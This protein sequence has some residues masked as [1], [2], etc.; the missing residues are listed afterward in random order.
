MYMD[1][2]SNRRPPAEPPHV[3]GPSCSRTAGRTPLERAAERG[4]RARVRALRPASRLA[5]PRVRPP[6]VSTRGSMRRRSMKRRVE[7]STRCSRSPAA[8][9]AVNRPNRRA[10]D[11]T[12]TAGPGRTVSASR[13]WSLHGSSP[14]AMWGR[15]RHGGPVRSWSSHPERLVAPSACGPRSNPARSSRCRSTR[16]RTRSRA[17]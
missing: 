6:T 7:K 8:R 2:V 10:G 11:H 4:R 13:C 9:P 1:R 16:S 14:E 12:M 15:A 5:E 3:R 17:G